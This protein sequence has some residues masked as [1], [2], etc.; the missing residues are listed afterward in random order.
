M[1]NFNTPFEAFLDESEISA[2]KCLHHGKANEGQQKM[3]LEA[4]FK[5]SRLGKIT[6]CEENSRV[7]DFNE[8]VRYVGI[9]IAS[10]ITCNM[11]A[12]KASKQLR[13]IQKTKK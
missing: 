4:I 2:I 10:V 1:N 7:T 3:A 5:I 9:Q 11:A 12:I 8:G 6:F 13:T